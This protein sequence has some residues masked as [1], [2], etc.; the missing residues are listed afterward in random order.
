MYTEKI[1]MQRKTRNGFTLIELIV[2]LIILAVLAGIIVPAVMGAFHGVT[3]MQLAN[4]GV[5]ALVVVLFAVL[6]GLGI[7][8]YRKVTGKNRRRNPWDRFGR[9]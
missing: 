9:F 6:I 7:F 5:I 8:I 1:Q 4:G 2:V 3:A